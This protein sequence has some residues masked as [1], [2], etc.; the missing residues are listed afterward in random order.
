MLKHIILGIV[1][2]LTEFLPVSS[3]GH[4]VILQKIFGMAGEEIVLTIILHLGTLLAIAVFFW[5]DILGL[6][7]NLKLC[8]LI[9]VVTVITGTLGVLGKDFF[10][11]LFSSWKSVTLALAVNGIF[12]ICV[13]MIARP[14][15]RKP[16]LKDALVLGFTQAIAIIP[17]I[18]RSGT[19]ISTLLLR[20]ID[21]LESFKFSFL[22]SLPVI[23]GAA[24][25]ESKKIN[26]SL[27]ADALNLSVG[28]LFSF[29]TGLFALWL[30]RRVLLKA[31]LHYFGYYCIFI[32]LIALIFLR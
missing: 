6:A 25:L 7:R 5:K 20:K 32:A 24:L 10:E 3:S 18:S 16:G 26:F 29:L 9:L 30:L 11:S 28:F 12:L 21:I 4:L 2:G 31:K 27:K 13:Q 19:T 17:G 15:K 23:M 14:Q 1:Q 8:G 22:V